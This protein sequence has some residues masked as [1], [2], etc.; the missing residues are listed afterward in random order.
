MPQT[1]LAQ[2]RLVRPEAT[3]DDLLWLNRLVPQQ[4]PE[5]PQ[6]RI[7]VPSWL[8]DDVQHF[9]LIIH[10]APER[11]TLPTDRA[12]DLVEMPTGGEE[13]RSFFNRRSI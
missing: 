6:G 8:N 5:H 13:G 3:G 1:K 12:H 10:A 7:V 11:H 9:A 2:C 4:T